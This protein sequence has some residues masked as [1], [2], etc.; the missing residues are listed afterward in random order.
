MSKLARPEERRA[1]AA[2][3]RDRRLRTAPETVGLPRGGRRRTPGLRREEVAQL[4]G[5]GITWYT[6]FEQGRDIQVSAEF[7]ERL[8]RAF[9]LS[10]AERGHLF[11]LAQHRPPPHVPPQAVVVSERV[12]AV[13]ASLPGP[14]Y[15]KTTRWD[16]VAW[17][18]A[19][20]DAL[21]D[22][23]ALTEEGRNI[24]RLVFSTPELRARMADWEGDA[25]RTLEK[26]R[27]DYARADGDP[28]FEALVSEL[29]Q[30]SAEFAR[31]WPGQEVRAVGEGVKR[32]NHPTRGRVEYEHAT[33]A[34]EGS[35]DLRMVV[36]VTG[37]A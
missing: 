25:R 10:P 29:K 3:V 37:A 22:F 17:N 8:A 30:T 36:Y 19:A 18:E 16:I 2:F 13:L 31:W 21:G 27:L 14:A 15:V 6:W 23:A 26:F 33:F 34:I 32:L 20:I 35:P 9:Q 7:L 24:L 1:V 12:R 11:T 5:V 4:A 28:G